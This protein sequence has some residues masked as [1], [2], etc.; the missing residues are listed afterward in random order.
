[1]GNYNLIPYIALLLLFYFNSCNQSQEGTTT[2][3]AA[4]TVAVNTT[5]HNEENNVSPEENNGGAYAPG[6]NIDKVNSDLF[7]STMLY[8]S[9]AFQSYSEESNLINVKLMK[10]KYSPVSVRQ[11]FEPKL[12]LVKCGYFTEGFGGLG[13]SLVMCY[14]SGEKMDLQKFLQEMSDL[15]LKRVTEHSQP[16]AYVNPEMIDWCWRIFY[17]EPKAQSFCDVSLNTI[18]DVVFKKFVRTLAIAHIELEGSN[19]ENEKN[20]YRNSVIMEKGHAP[21]LLNKRY[22]KPEKYDNSETNPY[23]YPYASGFWLRRAIDESAPVIWNYVRMIIMDYD[24]E[25]GCKNL[26]ICDRG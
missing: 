1:M 16:F 3:S 21:D 12:A 17:R 11:D 7:L 4:D 20:W 22:V 2:T 23:Y 26:R 14:D 8:H 9:V 15:P 18:Y 19:F 24:Y 25:W 10:N 6:K 13:Q 5:E